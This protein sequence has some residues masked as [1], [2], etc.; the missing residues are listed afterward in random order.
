MRSVIK[1]ILGINVGVAIIGAIVCMIY[2]PYI[3]IAA[4]KIITQYEDLTV[5]DCY[6]TAVVLAIMFV[7]FIV[8]GFI[9]FYARN[10]LNS[11]YKKSELV[12]P[13]ILLLIFVGFIPALLMIF[14]PSKYLISKH[15]YFE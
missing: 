6:L 2:S 10:K 13:I 15:P 5:D 11:A 12:L 1:I 14:T 9:S 7:V 8:G 4:Q 3:A